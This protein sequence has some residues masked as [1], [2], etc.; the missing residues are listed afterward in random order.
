MRW[1]IR[2]GIALMVGIVIGSGYLWYTFRS[3]YGY[4]PPAS[5]PI[6]DT[7]LEQHN[8]FVYG[9]LRY[10][11]IRS[12]VTGNI[13]IASSPA[14]LNGYTRH[15]LDIAPSVGGTVEGE[16]L[17][18]STPALQR[19]DRYERIGARYRRVNVRLAD[20]TSAWVYRRI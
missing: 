11:L 16:L 20:G 7:R 1:G 14:T 17:K 2:L 15:E 8:V 6:V 10:V 4:E 9:T 5:P 18:V 13:G 19:L 3:P 12:L